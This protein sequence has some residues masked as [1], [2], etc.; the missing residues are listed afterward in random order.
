MYERNPQA[1][2]QRK[3]KETETYLDHSSVEISNMIYSFKRTDI[4]AVKNN[5]PLQLIPI[6]LDMIVLNHNDYHI[7]IL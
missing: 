1:I 7:E 5:L 3:I 4:E 6:L 2:I